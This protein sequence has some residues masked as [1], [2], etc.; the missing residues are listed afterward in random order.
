MLKIIF[1]NTYL[2]FHLTIDSYNASSYWQYINTAVMLPPPLEVCHGPSQTESRCPWTSLFQPA[3]C[4]FC[5][6]LSRG[7]QRNRVVFLL[8][9]HP[10]P[11]AADSSPPG[12]WWSPARISA[13]S[14]QLW[15]RPE[16]NFYWENKRTSYPD[17]P[18]LT[19]RTSLAWNS[20]VQLW[21]IIPIP[22]INWKEKR[23]NLTHL[24]KT[25]ETVSCF[26]GESSELM[27]QNRCYDG[28]VQSLYSLPWRWPWKTLSLYPWE[29]KWEESSG[30][31]SSLMQ[32][33]DPQIY[34]R[35]EGKQDKI[36]WP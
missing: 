33:S 13:E 20:A 31:S 4:P 19:F 36:L 15:V 30:L 26:C 27:E 24:F 21:W 34:M 14:K 1:R 17:V 2:F 16:L 25:L 22:P 23:R 3:C 28:R 35:L 10:P 12:R 18:T 11:C 9:I 5:P 7:S 6:F 32:T 29:T 8:Q